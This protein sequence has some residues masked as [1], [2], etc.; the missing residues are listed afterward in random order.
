[1]ARWQ[2]LFGVGEQLESGVDVSLLRF[3]QG[4][5]EQDPAPQHAALFAGGVQYGQGLPQG[6][7][8]V[9]WAHVGVGGH[10][11]GVQGDRLGGRG[12]VSGP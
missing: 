6:G 10:P 5:A 11:C 9:G 7:G 2:E 4:E 3:G 1:M 12:V 8:G